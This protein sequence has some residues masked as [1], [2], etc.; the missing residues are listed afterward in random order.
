MK[1]KTK[2]YGEQ[3]INENE[4]I[5]F[6]SGIPGFA[7]DKRFILQPFGEAFSILQSLDDADV[8]FIVT[9]P[10]LY[11]EEYS[12]DL[13]DHLV[14]QLAIQSEQDVAIWVIVSVRKPFSQSTANLKAPII[15][16]GREQLGK[17]YIPDHSRYSLR[18]RLVATSSEERA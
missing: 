8:A 13:P 5:S 11:F 17:Q 16:N 7:H 10:F 14:Q 12:I 18:E 15:I 2:Y 4:I 3:E 6:S 9:S 1:I